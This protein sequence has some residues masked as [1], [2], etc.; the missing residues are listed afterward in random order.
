[1][2]AATI[3]Q[4]T[5]TSVRLVSC[6]DFALLDEFTP[7]GGKAITVASGNLMQ[8]AVVVS[9]GE[10]LCLEL[11][12]SNYRRLLKLVGSKQLDH[13]VACLS[14]RP[15]TGGSGADAMD[16]ESMEA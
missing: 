1:M 12:T 16:V 6:G 7:P 3:V 15:V 2:A 14:L 4:V 10:L 11:D 13:D 9:G 8:L 5:P